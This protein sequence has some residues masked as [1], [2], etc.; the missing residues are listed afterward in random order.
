MTIL[1][2]QKMRQTSTDILKRIQ[3]E[4]I[5][6]YVDVEVQ[7]NIDDAEFIGVQPTHFKNPY[8]YKIYAKYLCNKH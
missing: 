2:G 5:R 8:F 4:Y 7:M 1:N 3:A 6:V